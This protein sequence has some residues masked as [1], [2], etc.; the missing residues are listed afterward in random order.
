MILIECTH[1]VKKCHH[2]W[3]WY[4]NALKSYKWIGKLFLLEDLVLRIRIFCICVHIPTFW[5][6]KDLQ[7]YTGLH[8][9]ISGPVPK[10]Q[11]GSGTWQDSM[12]KKQWFKGEAPCVD[13]TLVLTGPLLT[14]CPLK[15]PSLLTSCLP[16]AAA[17][18]APSAFFNLFLCFSMQGNID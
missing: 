13:W 10:S 17:S 8:V 18:G 5:F 15:S 2:K 4:R 1:N 7:T 3:R 16:P 6:V 12:L 9:K 14:S 11:V